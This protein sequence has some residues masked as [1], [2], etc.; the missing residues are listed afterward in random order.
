MLKTLGIFGASGF[1]REVNDIASELG[2]RT[3]FIAR[4]Q[5]IIEA[6]PFSD[7]IILESNLANYHD[8]QFAIGVGEN[9]VRQSIAERYRSRHE[10]INLIHPSATFGKNQ[11]QLVEAN[12]GIII[13]AGVRLTNNIKVG[14][15]SILNLNVTVGHDVI[16]DEFVNVAPGVN[17]SGNVHIEPRCWIGTGV[18]INQGTLDQNL[19][20]GSDTTIGSGSVV[21]K[22]CEANAVYVGIPAKRIK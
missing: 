1:A 12:Q 21:V 22:S 6:W 7:D 9:K 13:C 16:I 19:R 11:R 2:F 18:A 3:I 8:L 15:F 5:Q 17:I 14:P 10:F 4:D 20:V